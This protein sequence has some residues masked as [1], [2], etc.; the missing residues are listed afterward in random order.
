MNTVVSKSA[1]AIALLQESLPER[2]QTV[3]VLLSWRKVWPLSEGA[4]CDGIG[5]SARQSNRRA[6][7]ITQQR[8]QLRLVPDTLGLARCCAAASRLRPSLRRLR[9]TA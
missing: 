9:Y 1:S 4:A 8:S 7:R 6:H 5:F 2:P 3:D